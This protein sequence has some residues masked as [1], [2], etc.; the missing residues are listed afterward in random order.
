MSLLWVPRRHVALASPVLEKTLTECG[1]VNGSC[2]T[3]LNLRISMINFIHVHAIP[4]KGTG[5]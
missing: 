2:V 1:S 3:G 5:I 4:A